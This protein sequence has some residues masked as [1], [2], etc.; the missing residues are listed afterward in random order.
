MGVLSN[1]AADSAEAKPLAISVAPTGQREAVAAAFALGWRLAELYVR[2]LVPAP[3]SAAGDAPLP[4][5]LP[6][7]SQMSHHEQAVVVLEKAGAAL[8]AVEAVLGTALPGLGAVRAALD[9]PGHHRDD[10]RRAIM[11]AY[12]DIRDPLLGAAPLAAVSYGLGRLLADTIYLPR[13]HQPDTFTGQFGKYRLATGCSWLD[14]LSTAFPHRAAAAVR[15]SL[16]KWEGWVAAQQSGGSTP[17]PETFGEPALRALHCQGEM[18]RRLLTGEKD[19]MQLLDSGDY[20]AAGEQ[21]LKRGRQ[22]G[23]H[24][25]WHWWPVIIVFIASTAAAIWAAITYAPAS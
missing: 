5:H 21:L 15:T 7:V 11:A 24:F 17:D 8:A 16:Q 23:R 4:D 10:V 6:G 12:L 3:G 22:I 9:R 14:D 19:P 18:W 13:S 2:D 1:I 20:V 25:L